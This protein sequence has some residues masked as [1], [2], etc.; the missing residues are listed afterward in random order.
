[1]RELVRTGRAALCALRTGGSAMA[2]VL[3]AVGLMSG[4][5]GIV[6]A[7]AAASPVSA[8]PTLSIPGCTGSMMAL[9]P[10]DSGS[11]NVTFNLG[12]HGAPGQVY[13]S[14]TTTST[15]A[16]SVVGTEALLD[17]RATGLQITL[18]DFT[19]GNG[20][21]IGAVSCTGAYPDATPC[22]SNDAMQSVSSASIASGSTDVVTVRW[23]F[24]LQ[25]GNPYQGASAIVNLQEQFSGTTVPPNGPATRTPSATPTPKGGTLGVHTTPSP[26]PSPHRGVL[27]A[28]TP[29]TGAQLPIVLSRVLIVIGLMLVFAGLWVWRRQ[30][31]F[32]R[33]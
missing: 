2:A 31:Y 26:S 28:S 12:G 22:S 7:V 8:A 20:Y 14:A 1:M 29:G 15:A 23:A 21:G 33:G 11:C 17:G 3:A 27:G 25:A 5:L 6:T 18:T 4:G 9:V 10:G 24:P 30:R 13:L 19:T 16:G 32:K